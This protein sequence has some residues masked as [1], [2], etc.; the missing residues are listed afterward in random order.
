MPYY[1][2]YHLGEG[3][4]ISTPPEITECADEREAIGKAS[5]AVNGKAVEG[6]GKARAISCASRAA[7]I[8]VGVL[9]GTIPAGRDCLMRP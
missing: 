8:N 3:D 6:F 5:Q 2:I 9:S 7:K 4:H 1:R